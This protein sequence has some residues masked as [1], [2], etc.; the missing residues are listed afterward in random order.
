MDLQHTYCFQHV[1][2]NKIKVEPVLTDHPLAHLSKLEQYKTSILS[3]LEIEDPKN[4]KAGNKY[5][6]STP[7]EHKHILSTFDPSNMSKKQ[8]GY[9]ERAFD[10]LHLPQSNLLVLAGYDY[11]RI[12]VV[13]LNKLEEIFTSK[14]RIKHFVG[15]GIDNFSDIFVLRGQH[16][17]FLQN[18]IENAW[19]LAALDLKH[20]TEH[21]II[22][23]P[24][25][26]KLASIKMQNDFL[27]VLD[28]SGILSRIPFRKN[29][30]KSLLPESAKIEEQIGLD[31]SRTARLFLCDNA[32]KAD[33]KYRAAGSLFDKAQG[34]DSLTYH[35]L[36]VA[37]PY[38]FVGAQELH[39]LHQRQGVMRRLEV[40]SFDDEKFLPN[41]KMSIPTG[42]MNLTAISIR[43]L[44]VSLLLYTSS[45][46]KDFYVCNIR[47]TPIAY[48]SSTA[49]GMGFVPIK[50]EES[51]IL[52]KITKLTLLDVSGILRFRQFAS[53]SSLLCV[54]TRTSK[55]KPADQE[56]NPENPEQ[57]PKDESESTPVATPPLLLFRISFT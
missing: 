51:R 10:S 3:F 50:F 49:E 56:D 33:A 19:T 35:K 1:K 7:T 9:I 18:L 38:I 39:V 4:P 40:I 24:L 25:G 12:K 32:A 16:V 57:K 11:R 44:G 41:Q 45:N 20:M 37:G 22:H 28:S 55:Q 54:C 23:E 6:F 52:T 31:P 14:K 42:I 53:D 26:L 8:L 27:Y 30:D 15:T 48:S 17:L 2:E 46:S 43:S 47:P 13:D 21:D 34:L 5:L 36:E 29:I